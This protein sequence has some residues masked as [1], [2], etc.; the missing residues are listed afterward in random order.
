MLH[1]IILQ[2]DHL[3][4]AFCAGSAHATSSSV[5]TEKLCVLVMIPP[6]YEE[7]EGRATSAKEAASG[8]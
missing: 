3:L 6:E 8:S 4:A 1:I 2:S 7:Q 5:T